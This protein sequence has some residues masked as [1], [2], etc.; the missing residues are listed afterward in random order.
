[1]LFSLE[2]EINF[3]LLLSKVD[4][5]LLCSTTIGSPSLSK[6]DISKNLLYLFA[7]SKNPTVVP[8]DIG[9]VLWLKL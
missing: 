5:T 2:L 1:M 9:F 4:T 3:K 7:L 6:F 8:K